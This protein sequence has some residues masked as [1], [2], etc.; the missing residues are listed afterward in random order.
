MIIIS[1]SLFLAVTY[2]RQCIEHSRVAARAHI[3][4][5]LHRK[6]TSV[7]CLQPVTICIISIKYNVECARSLAL[8]YP[9][10]RST[11]QKVP[12]SKGLQVKRSPVK[13][14]PVKRSTKILK[15]KGNKEI[16]IGNTFIMYSFS[17]LPSQCI[18]MDVPMYPMFLLSFVYGTLGRTVHC[19]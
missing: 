10:K 16:M 7:C 8:R 18:S 12:K 6:I 1:P 17:A 19:K 2:Q 11:S 13:R 3:I 14:S 9:V 5:R 4:T 15:P